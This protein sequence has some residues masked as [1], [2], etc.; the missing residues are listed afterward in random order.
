MAIQ[1]LLTEMG[2][3]MNIELTRDQYQALLKSLAITRFL[4]LFHSG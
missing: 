2:I 3:V 1:A 4:Y